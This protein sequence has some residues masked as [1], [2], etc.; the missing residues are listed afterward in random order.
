MGDPVT[1]LSSDWVNR[2]RSKRLASSA[3]L[4]ESG[5]LPADH[6]LFQ[7]ILRHQRFS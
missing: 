5:A 2:T 7:I 6:S 1:D 3:S 4:Q